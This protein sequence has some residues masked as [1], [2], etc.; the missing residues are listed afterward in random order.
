MVDTSSNITLDDARSHMMTKIEDGVDCPCCGRLVKLYK[1]KLHTE[2]ALFLLKLVKLHAIRST[3]L[4]T[5][6]ILQGQ[7][8]LVAGGTD[9]GF[10][11]HWGLIFRLRGTN[12]A[13]GKAGVYKP[14]LAGIQFV[15]G[16][17]S[18]PSH[19]HMLCGECIGFS[20]TQVTIRDCLGDKF[21]Y[22]ELMAE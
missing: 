20:S 19:V 5:T 22:D 18:V 4:K 9:G 14:T 1:R 13:G 10:L 11:E 2:M 7:T 8:H 17:T 15:E 12:K 6:E 16:K 3:W 21:D